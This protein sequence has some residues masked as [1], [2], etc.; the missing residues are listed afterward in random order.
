MKKFTDYLMM[1]MLAVACCTALTA[2]GGDDDNEPAPPQY[3][4]EAAKYTV[5]TNA[6]D[7][8]SIELTEAGEYIIDFSGN[9]SLRPSDPDEDESMVKVGDFNVGANGT[10]NLSGYGTLTIAGN[11]L[12]ITPA[13]G[14]PVQLTGRKAAQIAA[15]EK[16]VSLCRSWNTT[17]Y[18]L[19]LTRGNA[20][21]FDKMAPVSQMATLVR[22]FFK[23]TGSLTGSGP[24][25]DN[26]INAWLRE[27]EEE[28]P[29]K[30]IFTRAGTMVT[31]S[32][33]GIDYL[34]QW[35]WR[36]ERNS[37][38][39]V[40]EVESGSAT[41]DYD[42]RLIVECNGSE[43]LLRE[44]DVDNAGTLSE[45]TLITTWGFAAR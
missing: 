32:K 26:E 12:T 29:V 25:T 9:S 5:S 16:T 3:S 15:T 19:S 41:V 7:I 43:L 6:L 30:V 40:G 1:L 14:S 42:S 37:V 13:S 8:K 17:Q 18:G 27:A 22:E 44:L 21:V 10:I 11:K 35:R 2:C 38:I 45:T 28:M 33:G 36:D 23:V 24:A 39:E 4:D 31:R 34:G 20:S